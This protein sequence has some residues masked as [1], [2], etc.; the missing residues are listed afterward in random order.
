M[1]T[2]KKDNYKIT[3]PVVGALIVLAGFLLGVLFPLFSTPA[4]SKLAE[5]LELRVVRIE[6]CMENVQKAIE[7]IELKLDKAIERKK[8]GN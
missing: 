8:N 4:K 5:Q 3:W 7:R 1:P 6:T 2:K